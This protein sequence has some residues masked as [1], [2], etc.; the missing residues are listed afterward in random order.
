MST[1]GLSSSASATVVA[2]EMTLADL[3]ARG[4]AV[5]WFEAVAVVRAI[6]DELERSLDPPGTPDLGQVWLARG[7]I[8]RL[9]GVSYENEPVRRL[10]QLLQ[11][12]LTQADP[13]VSL[14]LVAG[15]AT[16]PV[17]IYAGLREFNDAVGYFER[18]DRPGVLRA[19]L[20]RAE[21]YAPVSPAPGQAL[22][23]LDDVAPLPA[24]RPAPRPVLKQSL[25]KGAAAAAIAIVAVSA[26]FLLVRSYRQEGGL[27]IGRFTSAAQQAT[28]SVS[29]AML[30]GISAVTERIGMGSLTAHAQAASVAVPLV[31]LK[32]PIRA[33]STHARSVA[34][35]AGT[36]RA[37][38][39]DS[40]LTMMLAPPI[41]AVLPAPP[42]DDRAVVAV[43]AAPVAAPGPVDTSVYS[44]ESPNVVPPTAI[45]PQFPRALPQGVAAA[46][47][48]RIEVLVQ[49]DG[50]VESVKLVQ[51]S[52]PTVKDAMLLS[53]A[54]TWRFAPATK[55]GTPV[56]YRKTIWIIAE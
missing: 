12:L 13:P 56:R 23:S 27:P 6:T 14:R 26:A 29:G 38:D 37:F 1:L 44:P 17:P 28:E 30:S 42:A 9:S 15:N 52:R 16:A 50:T 7:G 32:R 2:G 31:D 46:N 20:A 51:G 18:P 43:A 49:Q 33:G 53:A 47:L 40:Q 34:K 25:R 5:E 11:A 21:Q 55:E 24:Q 3:L 35:G 41:S 45:R 48:S 10:G 39:L 36:I 54:K 4:V 22:R 19:L 8:V